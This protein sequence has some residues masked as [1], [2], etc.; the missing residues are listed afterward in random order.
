MV[1]TFCLPLAKVARSNSSTTSP[2]RLT[3]T[4]N[5]SGLGASPPGSVTWMLTS[6]GWT[7]GSITVARSRPICAVGAAASSLARALRGAGPLRPGSWP[8][9]TM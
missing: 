2:L 9:R 4:L 6:P 1:T 8:I 5:M 7:A 3:T